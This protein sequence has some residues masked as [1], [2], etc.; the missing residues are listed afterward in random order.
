[1]FP[2]FHHTFLPIACAFAFCDLHTW[3]L[4]WISGATWRY[5]YHRLFSVM[6]LLSLTCCLSHR[7]ESWLRSQIIRCFSHVWFKKLAPLSNG[8]E[9]VAFHGTTARSARSIEADGFRCSQSGMLGAGVYLSRDLH[10]VEAYGGPEGVVVQVRVQLGDICRIEH[11]GNA[12]QKRWHSICDTAWVPA[13]CGMVGSGLEEL[14]IADPSKIKVMAVYSKTAS[15]QNARSLTRLGLVSMGLTSKDAIGRLQSNLHRKWHEFQSILRQREHNAL[16]HLRPD[17]AEKGLPD[18]IISQLCNAAVTP[19]ELMNRCN[20]DFCA[21]V[22]LGAAVPA[23][24]SFEH[25]SECH[26]CKMD[27][28]PAPTIPHSKLQLDPN[29]QHTL[30]ALWSY[31]TISPALLHRY[32]KKSRC[33]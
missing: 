6:A 18:Q 8:Q 19:P 31:A 16:W 20:V 13:N 33:E 23:A 12:L 25:T 30:S 1:M 27:A 5:G 26:S 32:T 4:C 21:R 14:C 22:E 7:L 3:L 17:V 29:K 2:F 9:I 28:A 15:I 11:Q 10:K 24:F